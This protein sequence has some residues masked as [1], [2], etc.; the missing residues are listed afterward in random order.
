LRKE[1]PERGGDGEVNRHERLCEVI[2]GAGSDSWEMGKK[3]GERRI[4]VNWGKWM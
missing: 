2:R 1:A 3:G 4:G